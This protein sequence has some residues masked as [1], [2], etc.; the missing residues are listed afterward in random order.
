MP[1]TNTRERY[2]SLAIGLHWLMLLLLA[3]VFASIELREFFP[4]NSEPRALM[5][6]WHFMLGLLVFG[7]AA[8]RLVWSLCN[9]TPGIEPTQPVWQARLAKLMH[10]AL[11]ALMLGVPIAGWL[12]LSGEGKPVPF[13][14]FEL[15]PLID[16]NR[17]LA[18]TLENIHE[19]AANIGLA[20]IG[21][22]AAA[23]L[24]HHHA[25]RDNTLSRM[26]PRR[27]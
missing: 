25:L 12:I 8:L 2:G 7:L 17:G 19:S 27:S 3:A 23:A 6:T 13:F 22:H 21:M 5:K 20:L 26:L 1:L 24:F 14:G 16:A 11:Y 15:P 18:K 4:K 9:V 10:L